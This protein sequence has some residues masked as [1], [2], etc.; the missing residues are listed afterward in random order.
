MLDN[1]ARKYE[2]AGALLYGACDYFTKALG[3]SFAE[4]TT[5]TLR[6]PGCDGS[7]FKLFLYWLMKKAL[8]ACSLDRSN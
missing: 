4:A 8:P 5:H 2:V 1:C 3:G 7:T 6:L